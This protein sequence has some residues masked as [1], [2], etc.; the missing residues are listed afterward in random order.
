[1]PDMMIVFLIW[2]LSFVFVWIR[3]FSNQKSSDLQVMKTKMSELGF[4]IENP[5]FILPLV[6]VITFLIAPII[7]IVAVVKDLGR[8]FS[9]TDPGNGK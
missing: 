3:M 7:A 8:I 5:E 9:K 2:S 6:V 1:M 4:F